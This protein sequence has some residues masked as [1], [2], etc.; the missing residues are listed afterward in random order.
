MASLNK[1][2]IIG[3]VGRVDLKEFGSGKLANISVAT[4][5]R[6]KDKSGEWQEETTWHNVVAYG[7]LASVMER[8]VQKGSNLYVEGRIRKRKYTDRDGNEKES[9]EVVA[10]NVELLDPK[11][12]TN[13]NHRQTPAEELGF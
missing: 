10:Q 1:I 11:Q 4:S 6:Y 12:S 13:N 3:R 9:V 7:S 2:L 8:F 5:E